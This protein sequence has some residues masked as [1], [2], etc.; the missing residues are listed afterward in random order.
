MQHQI[1]FFIVFIFPALLLSQKEDYQWIMNSS[2]IDDCSVANYPEFCGASI[3]DFNVDPPAA[4]R[5]QEATMDMDWTNASICDKEG[6][7]L[8]YSNNMRISDGDH[9]I[10]ANADTISYGIFWDIKSWPNEEGVM[11]P[12][13]F[14]KSNAAVFINKPGLENSYYHIYL[15][16]DARPQTGKTTKL[17]A[18]ID[19]VSEGYEV[20]FKDQVI[21]DSI[22]NGGH[23]TCCQHAN[24]RDW[25]LLQFS[26]D[27]VYTFLIDPQGI[28]LAHQDTMEYGFKER[29][30]SAVF[31][32]RGEQFAIYQI[33]MFGTEDGA[34]LILYDFD[35]CTGR[36]SNQRVQIDDSY[37]HFATPGVE[38]SA[39]G[40]YLYTNNL[41]KCYQYDTWSDDVF[42]SQQMVMVWDSSAFYN[43][44][45]T[46]LKSSTFGLMRRGPDNKIYIANAGQNTKIHVIHR[47]NRTAN[48]CY[49]EQN[50][51][52]LPTYV[53]GTIPTF[54]TL[55]LGPL[56]GSTCDTIGLDNHPVARFRYEQDSTDYLELDFVDLSYYEP[57]SWEWDFG[58][59]TSST[60]RYPTHTYLENGAYR[61][62]QTVSNSYSSDTTC[63]T[64]Y[65]GVSSLQKTEQARHITIF[66][67]P[68]EDYIR[69][70]IHDYIPQSASIRVYD[71]RGSLTM[72]ATLD[73][74][75]TLINV[76]A[77]A[78][79][80]Y[81]YE[82]YDETI[83]ISSGKI[84]KI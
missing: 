42:A 35:R 10:V 25:W 79:G 5:N 67:N 52:T 58:D 2:S 16:Y 11:Q 73:R 7:L 69:V 21:S 64:L 33:Y 53:L 6:Q 8:F 29:I 12:R 76:S 44:S 18:G 28:R 82:V 4:I 22:R 39:S 45:E 59:N 57:I 20:T 84:V 38:F 63:D 34:E 60:L 56:D 72:T 54:P 47:A 27:T 55:R 68:A 83:R 61:V 48:E 78:T 46:L 9:E 50:A 43:P 36:L 1:I 3:L 49:P 32:P 71:Q 77:L 30:S 75:A 40:Q 13:G 74:A 15:N 62:C 51:I 37:D 80:V 17:L 66:P 14:S 31:D 26:N 41:K 70:A 65:L 81:V 19:P 23:T 24:G